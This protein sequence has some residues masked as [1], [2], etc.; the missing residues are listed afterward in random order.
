M[1]K[2][3]ANLLTEVKPTFVFSLVPCE[4]HAHDLCCMQ[5]LWIFAW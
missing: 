3:P 2:M 1:L 5:V 4:M